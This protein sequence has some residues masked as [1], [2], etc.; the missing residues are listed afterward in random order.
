ME[1]YIAFKKKET[2]SH[3]TTWMKLEE[4]QSEI[5]QSQKDIYCMSP[6]ICSI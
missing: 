1:Y 3:P 2:L 5:D 4:M 6:L